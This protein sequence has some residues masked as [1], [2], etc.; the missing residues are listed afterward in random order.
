MVLLIAVTAM[1]F[2][3]W[4][5]VLYA[6][7]GSLLSAAAMYG[8]GALLGQNTLQRFLKGRLRNLNKQ[9]EQRGVLAVAVIRLM[10]V[11]PFTIVNLLAGAARIRLPHFLLGTALGMLPGIVLT[12]VFIDR[13]EAT[14]RTPNAGSLAWLGVAVAGIVAL[15]ALV[16]RSLRRRKGRVSRN[17]KR[18]NN[19]STGDAHV[20]HRAS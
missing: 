10:P 18:E 13:I 1:V 7:G 12:S 9:L 16:K 11:A 19:D 17:E 3:P 5:G 2:G 20:P 8:I 15:A 14:L 6:V 4:L